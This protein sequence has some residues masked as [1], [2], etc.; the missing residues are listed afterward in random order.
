MTKRLPHLPH[1][2]KAICSTV[3][4]TVKALHRLDAGTPPFSYNP[5]VGMAHPLYSGQISLE[6]AVKSCQRI[7]HPQ[8]AKSN[9]EVVRL[10]WQD[11]QGQ[12]ASFLCHPL[13][14]RLFRIRHDL[15]IPVKPRFF[16]VKDGI[17]NI[18]WL[19]PWKTFEL[20]EEQLGIGKYLP[21]ALAW[22]MDY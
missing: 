11:A 2:A 12:K 15:V 16:F 9:E 6:A 7:K 17:V 13:K 8:G 21:A 18:F 20:T 14:D 4:E 19:Q 3:P 10:I 5:A 1:I 22:Y